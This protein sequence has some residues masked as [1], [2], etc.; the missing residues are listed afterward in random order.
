MRLVQALRKLGNST[1]LGYNFTTLT[2]DNIETKALFESDQRWISE[3]VGFNARRVLLT[4][5]TLDPYRVLKISLDDIQHI[6]YSEQ[7]AIGKGVA[8]L[9]DYTLLDKTNE[10]QTVTITTT[11]S[12]SGMETTAVET[13][14]TAFPIHMVRYAAATSEE[15]EHVD[16][17]RLYAFAPGSLTITEDMELAVDGERY[18]I[19]EAVKELLCLRLSVTKR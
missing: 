8:F 16:F 14:S 9:Y 15:Q 7:R 10:A 13:L 11:P 18:V 1:L 19:T 6:V 12:A 17:S 5:N 3:R 4:E 2:W